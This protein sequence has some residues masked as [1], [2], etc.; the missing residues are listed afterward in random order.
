MFII[1]DNQ[2]GDAICGRHILYGQTARRISRMCDA[3]PQHLNNPKIGSCK[4]LLMQ[5][6]MDNVINDDS[7]SLF[8]LYQAPHWVT[9]FDLDYGSNAQGIF[10]AAFP[11]E[12]LHAVENGIF[13]HILKELLGKY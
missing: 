10:S 6:V 13:L 7:E 12:A 4:R 8:N 1:G 9:W 11:P 3:G 5:D 2:G